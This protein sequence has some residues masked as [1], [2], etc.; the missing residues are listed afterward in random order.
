MPWK[1]YH[2]FVV[3][4]QESVSR[5]ETLPHCKAAPILPKL[6][7]SCFCFCFTLK[8]VSLSA[9]AYCSVAAAINAVA[10]KSC[11]YYVF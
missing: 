7:M 6:L 11:N 10:I 5:P 2:V 8:S 1:S 9:N 3:E 4:T